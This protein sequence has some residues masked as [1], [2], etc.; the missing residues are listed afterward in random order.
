MVGVWTVSL[1]VNFVCQPIPTERVSVNDYRERLNCWLQAL[2]SII[3]IGRPHL[4]K[5]VCLTTKIG[6]TMLTWICPDLVFL[7]VTTF[8]TG[9]GIFFNRLLPLVDVRSFP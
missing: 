7:A 5:L 8:S 6:C 3:P 9:F 2:E 1:S 4:G